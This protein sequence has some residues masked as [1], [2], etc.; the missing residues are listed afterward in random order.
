MCSTFKLLHVISNLSEKQKVVVRDIGFSSIL[1][2]CCSSVPKNLVLWLVDRFDTSSNTVNLPNG[3]SLTLNAAVVKSILGLP[4]TSSKIICK[5]NEESYQF[6]KSHFKSVA[7]TPSV[8]ELVA[9]ITPELNGDHFARAFMLLVLASFLCPNSNNVTSSKYFKAVVSVNDIIKQDWCSLV[10]QWLNSSVLKYQNQ[11]MNGQTSQTGGCVLVLVIA[12][13]E[14]LY[15]SEFQFGTTSPR[16]KY[17]STSVIQTFSL[18]DTQPGTYTNF[19]RLPV[20]HLCCTPFKDC[21]E[22]ENDSSEILHDIESFVKKNSPPEH[23]KIIMSEISSLFKKFHH[24]IQQRAMKDTSSFLQSVLALVSSKELQNAIQKNCNYLEDS[25]SDSEKNLSPDALNH[26]QKKQKV[27]NVEV[28]PAARSFKMLPVPFLPNDMQSILSSEMRTSTLLEQLVSKLCSEIV[29]PESTEFEGDPQERFQNLICDLEGFK[30]E[31]IDFGQETSVVD[32]ISIAQSKCNDFLLTKPKVPEPK[33]LDYFI[34]QGDIN[35]SEKP[36]HIDEAKQILGKSTV[37]GT[38]YRGPKFGLSLNERLLG[39]SKHSSTI[40]DKFPNFDLLGA[41]EADNN[42]PPK[43]QVFT[44]AIGFTEG[45][46]K[47]SEMLL[48]YDFI[49]VPSEH[50]SNEYYSNQQRIFP[51]TLEHSFYSLLT[52][53]ISKISYSPRIFERDGTWV[54]LRTLSLSMMS[55]GW[56]HFRVMDCFCKLFSYKHV[57]RIFLNN[58]TT[59]ILM[60]HSLDYNKYKTDFLKII[61]VNP[62]LCSLIHIPCFIAKQWVLIVANFKDKRFDVLSPEYGADNTMKVINTVVYNFRNFFIMAFPSFQNLNIRDF[63]VCY[64]NVPKQQSLS[65]SGIF[66]TCFME[67]FD[68]TNIANF[69]NADIQALRE[70]KL[71]QLIFCKEN[72]AK[73]EVVNNF[74]RQYNVGFF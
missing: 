39:P 71:F 12:Y 29:L 26:L 4:M 33:E 46:R 14:F 35:S 5:R 2:L 74:R 42:S 51:S 16:I 60:D 50:I 38:F 23:F 21:F 54:D 11:K 28:K 53:N 40:D 10:L 49:S 6:I 56:F 34:P 45:F 3:F 15:T 7:R 73:A 48:N 30:Y 68:G 64:A 55:G 72:K 62:E 17:W 41:D 19:G 36:V 65:D 1:D 32:L 22:F 37:S 59:S 8:D 57:F 66:V 9:T 31:E 27:H 63:R 70:K 58:A 18:L 61:G 47:S 67:T 25:D 13:L 69:T 24:S 44:G 52:M 20:K 43:Q